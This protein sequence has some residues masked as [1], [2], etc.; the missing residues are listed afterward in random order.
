MSEQRLCI[1]DDLIMEHIEG[2]TTILT[3][4]TGEYIVLNPT[5]SAIWQGLAA[6][7]TPTQIVEYLVMAYLVTPA[8]AEADVNAFVAELN[9]GG[10]L[11]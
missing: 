3:P 4:S 7:Q 1:C 2:N 6:G 11:A 10:F 8:Q 9:A 5:A